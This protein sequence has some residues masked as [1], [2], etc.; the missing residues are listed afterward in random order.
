MSAAFIFAVIECCKSQDIEEK[1]RR[2]NG[3][4]NAELGGIIT[5][6]S[7]DQWPRASRGAWSSGSGLCRRGWC[8]CGSG[9]GVVEHVV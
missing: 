5:R 2:S 1:K 9:G 8:P 6:I 7:N 3:D 4:S